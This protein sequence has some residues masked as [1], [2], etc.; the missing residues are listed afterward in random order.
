MKQGERKH[1]RVIVDGKDAGSRLDAYL[2]R[3]LREYSRS[4]LKGFI[5]AGDVVVN[6]DA[7]PSDRERKSRT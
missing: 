5:A 6:G 4:R 1:I 3:T 2:G 7:A